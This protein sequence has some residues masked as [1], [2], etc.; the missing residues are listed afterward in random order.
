MKS[1]W[2]TIDRWGPGII[3]LSSILAL[4]FYAWMT[5]QRI[6]RLEG[7]VQVEIELHQSLRSE[8][9]TWQAYVFVLQKRMIEHQI[10]VPDPPKETVK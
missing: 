10:K 1:I 7:M 5:D 8:L 6:A 2:G 3:S 9:Q 4:I